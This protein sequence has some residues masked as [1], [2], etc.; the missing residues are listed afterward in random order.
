MRAREPPGSAE[1]SVLQ[2]KKL[3]C[4][5][6]DVC[7]YR[8]DLASSLY[9]DFEAFPTSARCRFSHSDHRCPIGKR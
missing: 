3:E 5:R 8:P 4:L 2:V 6:L 9:G 7:D 1:F